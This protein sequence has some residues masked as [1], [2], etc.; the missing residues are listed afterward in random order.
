M[1]VLRHKQSVQEEDERKEEDRLSL[2]NTLDQW[3]NSLQEA[4]L[5]KKRVMYFIA[6]SSSLNSL[7]YNTYF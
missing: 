7:T 3:F 5:Q 1:R 2:H 6:S 4:Q